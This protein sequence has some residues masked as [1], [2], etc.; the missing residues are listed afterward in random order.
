MKTKTTRNRTKMHLSTNNGRNHHFL[1]YLLLLLYLRRTNGYDDDNDDDV[2][3]VVLLLLLLLL[4]PFYFFSPGHLSCHMRLSS[5]LSALGRRLY[6]HE[7]AAA[8]TT[9]FRRLMSI[10]AL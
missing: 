2:V 3:V 5:A 4:A 10:M 8:M 6:R 1:L 9:D 7:R